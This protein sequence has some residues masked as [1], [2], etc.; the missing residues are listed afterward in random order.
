MA[1]IKSMDRIVDKWKRVATGAAEEYRVG[2]ENPKADWATETKNA[3]TRYQ[4]GVTSAISRKAFGKGVSKAGTSKW[5]SMSIAKGPSR[6]SEGIGLS[7]EAYREGFEPYARV[8]SS[9]SLPE[10]GHKGDPKNIARVTAVAN[11]LH[12]EKLKRAGS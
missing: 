1:N 10:R 5:Q 6:W 4:A 2:I 8:L 7:G 3:E 9:L 11:A 12:N